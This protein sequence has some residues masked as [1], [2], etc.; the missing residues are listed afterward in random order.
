MEKI[1]GKKQKTSIMGRPKAES[2]LD[3]NLD[4]VRIKSKDYD[5]L[6]QQAENKGLSFA[7]YVRELLGLGY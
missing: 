5:T 2:P 4:C 3:K 6:K 7:R 1:S